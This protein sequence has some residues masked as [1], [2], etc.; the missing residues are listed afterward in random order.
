MQNRCCVNGCFLNNISNAQVEWLLTKIILR[1]FISLQAFTVFMG[2]S[3]LFGIL[4]RS[5]W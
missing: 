5:N 3:L 2:N 4:L 1:N